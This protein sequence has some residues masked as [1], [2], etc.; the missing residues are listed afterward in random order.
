[1]LTGPNSLSFELFV[2][3]VVRVLRIGADL[4]PVGVLTLLDAVLLHHQLALLIRHLLA[5]REDEDEGDDDGDNDGDD[6]GDDDGD[7]YGDYYGDDGIGSG[8]HLLT[9]LLVDRVA[10]LARIRLTFFH[11]KSATMSMS[12]LVE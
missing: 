6:G 2:L 5:V 10:H 7:Y 12:W 11:C 9:V 1:M 3:V 8:R 4:A